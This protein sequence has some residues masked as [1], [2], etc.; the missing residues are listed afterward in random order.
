MLKKETLPGVVCLITLLHVCFFSAAVSGQNQTCR[1]SSCGDALNI[2]DPFRLKTD[3]SGCG[4][5][6]YELACE[7]N[8]TVLN[9]YSGKYYVEEINYKNYTIRVVDQGLKKGDC[10]SPPLYDL[11][12]EKFSYD[13]PYAWPYDWKFRTTILMSCSK[14]INENNEFIP[15]IPCNSSN[16]GNS[17]SSSQ[18]YHYAL[19]GDG[20]SLQVGDL[21]GSCTI[22][23]TI[24]SEM[25]ADS[26]PEIRSMSDLQD[27]I[28][29]G[30]KLSFLQIRCFRECKVKGENCNMNYNVNSVECEDPNACKDWYDCGQPECK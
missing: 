24:F 13:D 22:G 30:I 2:S 19:T 18:S 15:I 5:R 4:D 25:G 3:P 10:L 7:N 29:L 12:F 26:E 16:G 17:S 20:D 9:L 27:Q 6:R 8:R 28:L 21:P 11:N 1:P 14:Q 23:K